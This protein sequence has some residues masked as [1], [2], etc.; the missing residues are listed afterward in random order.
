MAKALLAR[1]LAPSGS[2]VMQ[3]GSPT[4]TRGAGR[5][6]FSA[7]PPMVGTMWSATVAGPVIQVIV[8]SAR[9]PAIFNISGA[10]AAISTGQDSAPGTVIGPNEVSADIVSPLNCTL[11]PLTAGPRIERYSRM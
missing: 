4:T 2:L 10:R 5:P 1:S 8:P 3:T 6:A 7:A 9:V 11:P